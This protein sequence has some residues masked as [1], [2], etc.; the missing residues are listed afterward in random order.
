MFCYMVGV[1]IILVYVFYIFF[2]IVLYCIYREISFFDFFW[3]TLFSCVYGLYS[4]EFCLKWKILPR[5]FLYSP[6]LHPWG[7]WRL[8]VHRS[9]GAQG[10][11][12]S[13]V[14]TGLQRILCYTV[15][16]ISW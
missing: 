9:Y 2:C 6:T 1:F 15:G 13:H 8:W 12:G 4:Y 7:S 11:I 16:F 5:E 10:C 14:F 3:A